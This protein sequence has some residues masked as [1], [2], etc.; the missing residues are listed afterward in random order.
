V[1]LIKLAHGKVQWQTL[2]NMDSIK[3]GELLEQILCSMK[4]VS[5]NALL[6]LHQKKICHQSSLV[7]QVLE[8]LELQTSPQLDLKTE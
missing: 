2:Q 4:V 5:F 3:G 6:Y 7:D 8:L 1:K